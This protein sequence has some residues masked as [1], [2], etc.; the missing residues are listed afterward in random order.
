MPVPA[1]R[2]SQ[3]HQRRPFIPTAPGTEPALPGILGRCGA[4]A[5]R[6]GPCSGL[7][8]AAVPPSR[9]TPVSSAA[10][11]LSVAFSAPVLAAAFKG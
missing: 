6:A 10:P 7:G 3:Q 9:V 4:V 2:S 1:L 8:A 11:G 5:A